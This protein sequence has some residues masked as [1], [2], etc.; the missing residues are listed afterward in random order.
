LFHK[1]SPL[2]EGAEADI[3]ELPQEF[4][5]A[6]ISTWN[7]DAGEKKAGELV[8]DSFWYVN[9]VKP[10]QEFNG[11]HP[12]PFP[13]KLVELLIRCWTYRGNLIVDP[14]N[15]SGTTTA[16][17][18]RLGRRYLGIDLSEEFCA[19]AQNRLQDLP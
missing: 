16:V 19:V 5:M 13:E 7:F 15:G 18:K 8:L 10:G 2:L 12:C 1:N 6:T 4:Q 11:H 9:S 14:F 17:A 3:D